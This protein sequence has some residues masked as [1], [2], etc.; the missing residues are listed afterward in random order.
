MLALSR[1]LSFGPLSPD[2]PFAD[3]QKD[4]PTM[5]H[6]ADNALREYDISI[7]ESEKKKKEALTAQQ[8]ELDSIASEINRLQQVRH[9]QII[10]TSKQALTYVLIFFAIYCAKIVSL[11]MF[12]KFGR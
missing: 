6:L 1:V 12:K 3:L 9:D 11:R 7:A 4:F 2:T 5:K 8:L 10:Q